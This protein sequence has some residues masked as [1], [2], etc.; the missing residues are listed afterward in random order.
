MISASDVFISREQY[1]PGSTAVFVTGFPTSVNPHFG[2]AT[3]GTLEFDYTSSIG[4]SDFEGIG[5][6]ITVIGIQPALGG[7][8]I[9]SQVQDKT[10][11][12]LRD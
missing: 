7:K 4:R 8:M 11:L 5:A 9:S 12:F 10:E 1:T 2:T 6:M 3:I